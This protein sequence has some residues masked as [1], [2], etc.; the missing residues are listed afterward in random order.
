MS[1]QNPSSQPSVPKAIGS[2]AKKQGDVTRQGTQKLKFV[3]TLPQRRKKECVNPPPSPTEPGRGRGETRG[4]PRGRGR[5]IPPA[6]EMT[7]SGPFA[8]GPSQAGRAAER[9]PTFPPP[10]LPVND[11]KIGK[12][13]EVKVEDEERY[14]DPDEGVEIV[15]MDQIQKIDWMAPDIL[16]KLRRSNDSKIKQ[17]GLDNIGMSLRSLLLCTSAYPVH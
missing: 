12:G 7:A 5:G 6:V 3:P 15:D 9:R 1:G 2:L 10:S 13:K 11:G 17:E 8:M 4:A 14:S 16:R